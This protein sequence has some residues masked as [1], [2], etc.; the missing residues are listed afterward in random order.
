MTTIRVNGR[1]METS[2]ATLAEH[3]ALAI[4]RTL[5]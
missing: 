2:A 1:P 3:N 5:W 4:I